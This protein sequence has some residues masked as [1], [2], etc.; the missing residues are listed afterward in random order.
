MERPVVAYVWFVSFS[1]PDAMSKQKLLS[2][3]GRWIVSHCRNKHANS[4][5]EFQFA[6]DLYI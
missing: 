5:F 6:N 4:V 3:N 1:R 2:V